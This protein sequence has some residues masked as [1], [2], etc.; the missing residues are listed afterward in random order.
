MKISLL[1]IEVQDLNNISIMLISKFARALHEHDGSVLKLS[2]PNVLLQIAKFANTVDSPQLRILYQRLK[3][4]LRNQLA[5]RNTGSADVGVLVVADDLKSRVEKRMEERQL[6]Q[7]FRGESAG[8]LEPGYPQNL[9]S[10][11]TE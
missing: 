1:D 3:L 10:L 11:L 4:E 8:A 2:D 5:G 6:E 7:V 9:D